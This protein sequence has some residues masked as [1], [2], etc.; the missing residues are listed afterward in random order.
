MNPFLE[1]DTILQMGLEVAEKSLHTS[2]TLLT[3]CREVLE[4]T[5]P[6][7]F[8]RL[9]GGW[10]LILSILKGNRSGHFIILAGFYIEKK[11]KRLT[12]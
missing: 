5:L 10:A 8:N 9:R 3:V 1:A 12:H 11:E 4:H 7:V 6:S 2:L